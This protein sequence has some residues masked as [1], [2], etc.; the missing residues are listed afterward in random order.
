MSKRVRNSKEKRVLYGLN[1]FGVTR[2]FCNQRTVISKKDSKKYTFEEYTTSVSRKDENGK[3]TNLY[4]P[5]YF[6]K[7]LDKPENNSLIILYESNL[8][9][10]GNKGYE[11]IAL[12][13]KQWDYYDDEE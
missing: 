13:V 7:G 1:V 11:R 8:F 5:I 6:E 4:I 2:I 9:V 12:Y 10:S 3:Y